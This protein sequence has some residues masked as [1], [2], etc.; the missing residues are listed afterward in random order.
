MSVILALLR[1]DLAL[2]FGGGHPADS[3]GLGTLLDVPVR[4]LSTGQRKRAAI[5]QSNGRRADLWL[6]DEPLNGLDAAAAERLVGQVG[7]FCASGGKA[8]I[9]SHQPFGLARLKTLELADY[10][11]PLPGGE[12]TEGWG[13]PTAAS[14][15]PTQ[16]PPNGGGE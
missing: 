4:Y 15:T 3:I 1:R 5:L 14:D 10:L 7:A 11:P 12:G 2:A 8:L 13:L 9:A 16:P 6:L